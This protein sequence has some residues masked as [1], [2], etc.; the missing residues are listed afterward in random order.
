MGIPKPKTSIL[1][2]LR[3]DKHCSYNISFFWGDCNRHIGESV[4][5]CPAIQGRHGAFAS[6]PKNGAM[7]FVAER[8][9][10]RLSQIL[11]DPN[12]ASD[13]GSAKS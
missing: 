10:W 9:V 13:Y 4:N 2:R 12:L 5:Y 3:V 1:F 6:P 7:C 11:Q 8:A